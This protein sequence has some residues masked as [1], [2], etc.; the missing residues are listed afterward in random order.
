LQCFHLKPIN[1]ILEAQIQED[2]EYTIF[3]KDREELMK[4]IQSVIEQNLA[5]VKHSSTLGPITLRFINPST[6]ATGVWTKN[7]PMSMKA[8]KHFKDTVLPLL[9]ENGIVEKFNWNDPSPPDP[10]TGICCGN[11]NSPTFPIDQNGIPRYVHQYKPVN[12]TL[13]PGTNDVP[14]IEDVVK[15]ISDKKFK[16]M[17]KIDIKKAFLQIPLRDCD[18]NVTAFSFNGQAYRYT[19]GPFGLHQMP[20]DFERILTEQL[21]KYNCM[22]F[23]WVHIDDLWI[24]GS[25][26]QEHIR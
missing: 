22:D 21:A 24:G 16:I 18:K 12:A 1:E 23:T 14:N 11:F 17:S 25:T 2:K 10:E 13:I 15:F 26:V 8:I 5:T 9:I 7:Y 6:R 3:H 19:R 20:S 4:S